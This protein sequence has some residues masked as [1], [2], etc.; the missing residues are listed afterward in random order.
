MNPRESGDP[1]PGD[2]RRGARR[3][4]I[5]PVS[6]PQMIYVLMAQDPEPAMSLLVKTNANPGS[7]IAAIRGK[8]AKL[9]PDQPVYSVR[10]LEEIFQEEHVFFWFNTLLLVAFAVMALVLSLIGIYAVM[11]YAVSQRAR[12]SASALRSVHHNIR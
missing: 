12:S 5:R 4:A 2:C 8:L 10:S 1:S 7:D 11:A 9:D 6:T 3:E